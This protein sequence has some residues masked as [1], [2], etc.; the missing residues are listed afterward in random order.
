M[1]V[2]IVS[3]NNTNKQSFGWLKIK[4]TPENIKIL[5]EIIDEPVGPTFLNTVKTVTEKM[6]DTKFFHIYLGDNLKPHLLSTKDAFW[7]NFDCLKIE[8][9]GKTH[10]D[11]KPVDLK[12]RRTKPILFNQYQYYG[13]PPLLSNYSTRDIRDINFETI[14]RVD[15]MITNEGLI[16]YN[17]TEYKSFYGRALVYDSIGSGIPKGRYGYTNL[18]RGDLYLNKIYKMAKEL[19]KLSKNALDVS[20]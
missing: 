5:D 13:Y 17:I 9:D 20:L 16:P 2:H 14:E 11:Y 6:K 10:F 12:Q 3:N 15:N 4:Q 7:G 19:E 8:Y 1:R 18:C